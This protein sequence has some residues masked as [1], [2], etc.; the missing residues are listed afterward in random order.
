[1][2]FRPLTLADQNIYNAYHQTASRLGSEASFA[3]PY[4][5]AS[6]FRTQIY[7]GH[8]FVCLSCQDKNEPPYFLMPVGP[9]DRTACIQ[10]LYEKCKA[11]GV[12]FV[13]KYLRKEDI[14]LVEAAIPVPLSVSA[15]RD[16]A[17]YIYETASLISLSGKKLHAKRN[18]VNAF[19]AA[20]SYTTEEMNANNLADAKAF[21]LARCK[22]DA[23]ILAM[24]KLFAE[25][26]TLQ[27]TG[28][29]LKVDGQLVAVTVGESLASRTALIHVEKA[30][31]SYTGAYATI[32]QLFLETFFSHT[33]Y[34]NREEDLGIDGLRRAKLSYRPAFL[35]DKYTVSEIV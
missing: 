6:S 34:V 18:H 5:W 7:I 11:D 13:L 29:L 24:E 19:K 25:Y 35:L 28:M 20:Y 4:I 12:P 3:T 1:M 10:M 9:G 23:E 16:V 2:E 22:D 21:V 14:P 31:I 17:D 15:P 27:F 32:N 8:D 26:F 33:L 30:D